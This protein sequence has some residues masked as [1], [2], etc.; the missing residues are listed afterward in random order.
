MTGVSTEI[1]NTR[2]AIR[3]GPPADICFV[4][5]NGFKFDFAV[6]SSQICREGMSLQQLGHY[7]FCDSLELLRVISNTPEFGD[8]LTKTL[9]CLKLQCLG[10]DLMSNSDIRA[11][12]ALDDAKTLKAVITDVSARIDVSVANLVSLFAQRLDVSGTQAGLAYL[13]TQACPNVDFK[14]PPIPYAIVFDS[15]IA[16]SNSRQI[17]NL[18]ADDTDIAHP[19]ELDSDICTE[20]LQHDVCGSS[21]DRCF[22]TNTKTEYTGVSTQDGPKPMGAGIFRWQHLEAAALRARRHNNETPA[23]TPHKRCSTTE[24]SSVTP[25]KHKKHKQ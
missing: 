24:F 14:D 10:S 11:H 9:C 7:W 20:N 5:H 21:K 25:D 15:H 19:T 6:L 18:A 4:A 17:E 3:A 8:A 12:R 13:C 23:S 16:P 22:A 1:A 2:G